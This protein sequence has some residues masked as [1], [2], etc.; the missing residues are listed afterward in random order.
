[1][2]V[3]DVNIYFLLEP[4]LLFVIFDE[5]L[6]LK[7]LPFNLHTLSIYTFTWTAQYFKPLVHETLKQQ[8]KIPL[9]PLNKSLAFSVPFLTPFVEKKAREDAVFL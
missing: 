7:A 4:K 6:S 1:M 2:K 8:G 9:G 5:P 3:Y